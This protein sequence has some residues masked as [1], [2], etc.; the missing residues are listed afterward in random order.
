MYITALDFTSA[1]FITDQNSP[2]T[3]VIGSSTYSRRMCATPAGPA[4][5]WAVQAWISFCAFL[6]D[7]EGMVLPAM[8]YCRTTI[9]VPWDVEANFLD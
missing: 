3:A 7:T 2:V 4:N 5:P 6:T 8:P 9:R 1:S